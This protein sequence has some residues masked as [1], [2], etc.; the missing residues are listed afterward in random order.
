MD[1]EKVEL[2]GAPAA[3]L[4]TL[5]GKAL[6]A[7]DAESA[8]LR[9]AEFDRRTRAALAPGATVPHV[10]AHYPV[11]QRLLLRA[12]FASPLKRAGRGLTCAFG[13]PVSGR[14]ATAAGTACP[15]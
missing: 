10:R 4:A 3:M 7:R 5:Y 8:V 13:Q 15:G 11:A 6:D 1:R 14:T 2:T 12:L 9:S